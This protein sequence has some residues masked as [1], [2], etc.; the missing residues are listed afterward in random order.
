MLKVSHTIHFINS[1]D[2]A[3][4]WSHCFSTFMSFKHKYH[5]RKETQHVTLH[6]ILYIVYKIN[7][8]KMHV[9]PL[10]QISLEI[11]VPTRSGLQTREMSITPIHNMHLNRCNYPSFKITG[12]LWQSLENFFGVDYLFLFF[13]TCL[14]FFPGRDFLSPPWK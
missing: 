4:Y 13:V 10:L 2:V 6:F 1:C 7:H 11:F 3:K 5:K 12:V 9:L 14:L 8:F